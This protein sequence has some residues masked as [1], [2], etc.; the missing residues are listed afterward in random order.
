MWN[1][2]IEDSNWA[3]KGKKKK[4]KDANV[5]EWTILPPWSAPHSI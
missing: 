1:N 5:Q 3:Q 4:K 2:P